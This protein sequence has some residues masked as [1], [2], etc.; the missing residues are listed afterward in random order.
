M[1]LKNVNIALKAYPNPFSSSSTIEFSL[2][3][4][5]DVKLEVYDLKGAQIATLYTGK[6]QRNEPVLVE[7]NVGNLLPGIYICMLRT[8]TSIY[9]H[10][11]IFV[12]QQ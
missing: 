6:A 9:Y 10:R 8:S 2:S 7:F 12:N 3:N 4:D 5:D 11:L 1:L